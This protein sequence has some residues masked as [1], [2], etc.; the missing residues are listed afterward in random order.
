M[1][2][3]IYFIDFIRERG[4]TENETDHHALLKFYLSVGV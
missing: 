1:R 3:T 4:G 2:L